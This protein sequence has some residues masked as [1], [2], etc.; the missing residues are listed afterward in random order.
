MNSYKIIPDKTI[1]ENGPISKS[2]LNIGMNTFHKAC[3]H[4]LHLPYGRTSDKTDW[5]LVLIEGQGTCSTKHAL[6]ST[7]AAELK[8]DVH[9][10]LGIYLMKESN[11]P[12][13]GTILNA[14]EYDFLPEAHC[15]LKYNG[16]RI[17]ITGLSGPDAEPIN[18]FFIEEQIL[19][20]QIGNYKQNFHQNYI[21]QWAES[22]NFNEIWTLR[23]AC[24]KALGT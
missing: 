22:S 19:P 20:P 21:K 8:I 17:D 15:Y 2:F 6:I 11:T 4:V 18:K 12:G 16:E 9:L 5:T 7:L 14:S 24:I 23:E 13:V 3:D 1:Q 10:M